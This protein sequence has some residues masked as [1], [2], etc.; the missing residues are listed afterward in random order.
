MERIDFLT[1][2]YLTH[3]E[4]SR[5]R[6]R[7]GEVEFLT[8]T[9][10]VEKYLKEGDKIIEIGAG[11]GRYSHYFAEKGYSVDAIELMDCNIE[12][13]KANTK[14]FENVT[15]SKGD[16]TE[17]KDV[18]S[19]KYD[20]TLLL[21][22]MYHLYTEK[23]QLAAL[24]EALR[25]TKK[26]GIIFAAYCNNDS[27]VYSFGFLNGGFAN[28][29]E[30]QLKLIDFDTFKLS[31][32]PKEVFALHRRE[33]IDALMSNFSIERLHYVASDMFTRF[34]KDAVDKM[35]DKTFELYMKYHLYICERG[36]MVGITSHM[37]DIF[38]KI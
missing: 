1:N 27:T 16:A 14:P 25:V 31:S 2:Y 8:T 11:S 20:I 10:Y 36:D 34:I 37:L 6:S 38:R 24:S 3:N 33:D 35:D 17:L 15:I 12:A 5:L 30:E 19:E 9:Y 4:D 26:G 7:H 18:E 13:F 21:G 28:P 23:E 32:T 22:P 29:S